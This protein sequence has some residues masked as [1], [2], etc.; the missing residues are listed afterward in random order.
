MKEST[1]EIANA[2][3][4]AI[5]SI[6]TDLKYDLL[7]EDS[8]KLENPTGSIAKS[9]ML[10]KTIIYK[11]KESK[12]IQE[13]LKKLEKLNVP[14]TKNDAVNLISREDALMCLTGQFENRKYE[15][16]ELI[17]MFSK[18]IKAL[19]SSPV[20][21]TRKK[22]KWIVN[23]ERDTICC[24]YCNDKTKIGKDEVRL[25]NTA[26]TGVRFCKYCGAEMRGTKK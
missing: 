15:P 18:R 20:I 2:L 23:K 5:S 9:G 7:Y 12:E 11:A 3:S 6:K 10:S 22:G 4:Y 8:N 13:D 26:F 16:S 1:I 21:L 25:L 14:T 17:V 19:S 24:P